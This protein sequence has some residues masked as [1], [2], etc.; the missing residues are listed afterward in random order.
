MNLYH[1][2][3]TLEE[4][5]KLVKEINQL[6]EV[7]AN[8]LV[9]DYDEEE[10]VCKTYKIR[11]LIAQLKPTEIGKVIQECRSMKWESY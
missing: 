8:C 10:A 11:S 1:W 3:P 4:E 6:S 2:L 5:I 9:D 7:N